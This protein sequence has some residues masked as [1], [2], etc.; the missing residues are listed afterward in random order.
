M[1]NFKHL[2]LYKYPILGSILSLVFYLSFAYDLDRSNHIKLLLLYASLWVGFYFLLKFAKHNLKALTIIA[3][4]FRA[5]FILSIPNLSQD[6]Y[7]FIWDG[8]LVLAGLNPYIF[9][10][11]SLISATHIP[12][13]QAQQLYEGMGQLSATHFSN[14][15]PL[16]QLCFSVAAFFAGHSILGSVVVLRLI[17][18]AA[19][20]GTLCFGRKL[21]RKLKLPEHYIFWYMLNPFIIIELTGNLHFEGLMI[22]F[23]AWSLSLLF[24]NQWKGAA[25]V[26]ALS[27]SVKLMP[28][29]FLPLLF[30]YFQKP[31][32][33]ASAIE[34][35]E[36][37]RRTPKLSLRTLFSFYVIVGVV[38]TLLFAPFFSL[39]FLNNYSETVA[40]W[41]TNFEFNASI[42]YL[43]REI[44]YGITGYN[45]IAI[46]GKTLALV[47]FL[48]IM[49]LAIF[50]RKK[51]AQRF[52]SQ[53]LIAF[54]IFLFLSTTVHPW[55]LTTLLFL[56]V[57]TNYKFPLVWS[58]VIILSYLAYTTTNETG[59]HE[60][61]W[62]IGLEYSLVFGFIIWEG[63]LKK[64]PT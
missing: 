26:F 56:S 11:E 31:K 3:F 48:L 41:F 52:I 17:I 55:Y 53:L 45:E 23:L 62:L 51:D 10:P 40:L 30:G 25:M 4:I 43:A 64:K 14:Y 7:R 5:V 44:G 39:E 63:L 27:V 60:N 33:S 42:Y 19:D 1:L 35:G 2:K 16:N 59:S 54:A 47:T 29:L 6:F 22:F 57:F 18:I 58:A 49:G 24:S 37:Q 8:R 15:P 38:T 46:I 50:R 9:T 34:T 20:F 13:A 12:I 28:L 32:T 61:L 21:L 36:T